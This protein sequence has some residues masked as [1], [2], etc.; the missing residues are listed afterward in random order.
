MYGGQELV[1][2]LAAGAGGALAAPLVAVAE[3]VQSVVA[4][5]RVRHDVG[6]G[7]DVVGNEGVQGPGR[8]I[9]HGR[10][11][12]PAEPARLANLDRDGGEHL[13]APGPAAA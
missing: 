10:N 1:G 4:Q 8:P 7:L 6:S 13:L 3:P 12:A 9:C 2:I 11:P 5:P